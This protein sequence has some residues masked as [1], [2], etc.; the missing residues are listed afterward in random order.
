MRTKLKL[1]SV[2]LVIVFSTSPVLANKIWEE[3][4]FQSTFNNAKSNY[5]DSLDNY[6]KAREDYLESLNK[7]KAATCDENSKD[8]KSQ[9][10]EGQACKEKEKHKEKAIEKARHYLLKIKDAIA[11]HLL[12][13]KAKIDN[14]KIDEEEKAKITEE[15]SEALEWLDSKEIEINNLQTAEQV[16]E[17]NQSFRDFWTEEKVKI[18]KYIG[19][20]MV[21][22]LKAVTSKIEEVIEKIEDRLNE[23]DSEEYDITEVRESLNEIKKNLETVKSKTKEAED[24]FNSITVDTLSNFD[25][26][27]AKVKEAAKILKEIHSDLKSFVGEIN[28]NKLKKKEASGEGGIVI[29]GQGFVSII[30]NGE[31]SGQ[32][33]NES[34]LGTVTITDKGN[35]A[36]IE[37]FGKGDKIQM[38]DGSIQYKNIEKIKISGSDI[39]VEI[40]S[41]FI[42]IEAQGEG[43]VTMKGD[44]LYKIK[45]DPWTDISSTEV[46]LEL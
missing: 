44:G 19:R 42:D 34:F 22:K 4:G 23:L 37:T 17:F 28:K 27:E 9:N 40:F 7:Y 5:N 38:G 39:V 25:E 20:I 6:G 41:Q 36:M 1:I 21:Y 45:D 15:I 30:V 29:K 10:K 18:K 12:F 11:K 46:K 14:T 24:I 8:E 26:G 33:G 35:D 32:V 43:T 3:G 16:K 13:I 2:F 31:V